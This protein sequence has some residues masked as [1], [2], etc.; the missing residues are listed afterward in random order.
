MIITP[1]QSELISNRNELKE[2]KYKARRDLVLK[3]LFAIAI[4]ATG[5]A[6]TVLFNGSF[7]ATGIGIILISCF[8]LIQYYNCYR[9][10]KNIFMVAANAI[11]NKLPENLD[12]LHRET[13]ISERF[14][15]WFEQIRE[16]FT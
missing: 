5:I 13:S 8:S 16:S 9:N 10:S 3:S 12:A 1:T 7:L 4:L 11:T 2:L 6:L 15:D 14:H